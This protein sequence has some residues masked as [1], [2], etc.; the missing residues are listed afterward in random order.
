MLVSIVTFSFNPNFV[1]PEKQLERAVVA[2]CVEAR[3][4][5]QLGFVDTI[6]FEIQL[7]VGKLVFPIFAECPAAKRSNVSI[8][9]LPCFSV[10]SFAWIKKKFNKVNKKKTKL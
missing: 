7:Q 8:K 9:L 2:D 1:A 6:R 10:H 4:H 3:G 5:I